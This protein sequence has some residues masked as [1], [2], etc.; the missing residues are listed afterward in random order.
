MNFTQLRDGLRRSIK[1]PSEED[2][3]ETDLGDYI[4]EGYRDLAG[5][6]EYHQTRKR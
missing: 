3:V 6:Y 4:N 5:R 1:N 2:V